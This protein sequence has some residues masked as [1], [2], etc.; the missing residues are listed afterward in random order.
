MRVQVWMGALALA[1]SVLA[2]NSLWAQSMETEGPNLDAAADVPDQSPVALY[3]AAMQV[4]ELGRAL[5]DP[6]ILIAAARALLDVGTTP[7]EPRD[8]GLSADLPPRRDGS[9]ATQAD[10]DA[11]AEAAAAG[12]VAD[13]ET[14]LTEARLFARGDD[15]ILAMIDETQELAGRTPVRGAHVYEDVLVPAG[16]YVTIIEDYQGGS[17]AEAGFIGYGLSNIDMYVYDDAGNEI[18]RSTGSGDQEYCSWTPLWTGPFIIDLENIGTTAN[19]GMLAV[20]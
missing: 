18:C 15:T 19:G 7:A 11:A 16:Y 4:A 3:D 5:E 13:A 10:I 2:P 17:L 12:A 9:L 20:N 8:H 6:V 1:S 14:L